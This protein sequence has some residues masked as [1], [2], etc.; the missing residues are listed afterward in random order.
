MAPHQVLGIGSVFI[1]LAEITKNALNFF[2]HSM[3]E[4]NNKSL[5]CF[6]DQCCFSANVTRWV[7]EPH[8]GD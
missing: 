7:A 1:T 5:P 4:V 6:A 2:L 8:C 3:P